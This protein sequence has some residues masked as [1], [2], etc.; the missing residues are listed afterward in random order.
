MASPINIGVD[1][2]STGLR[3]AYV[4]EGGQVVVLPDAV[5]EPWSWLLYE[6]HP[7][8]G[9]GMLFPSLKHKLGT[10][11]I[12]SV[13]GERK[14]PA[15]VVVEAFRALKQA[16]EGQI[17]KLVTQ[18][19]VSVPARYST[20]QR[21]AL[22]DAALQ[23]GFA[24]AHLVNDTVAAVIAYTAQGDDRATVLVYSMGYAGFE[25]GLVRAVRG[26]Y[27]ALG[28]EGGS[29]PSGGLIDLL[30]LQGW[31]N[32]LAEHKLALDTRRWDAAMGLQVRAA[33][34]MVKE[35]LSTDD[36]AIFPV[37]VQTP[38]GAEAPQVRFTRSEVEKVTTPSFRDTL[39]LAQRLLEQTN[40]T[41]ADVDTI[42]LVG[43]ST[44]IPVLSSLVEQTLGKKPVLAEAEILAQGAAL[45]A[46]RLEAM[47]L[48]TGLEAEKGEEVA[49]GLDIPV[50][51]AT[52]RAAIVASESTSVRPPASEHLVLVAAAPQQQVPV[53]DQT[54][55]LQYAH[56]LIEGGQ[57]EQARVF[58]QELIHEAQAILD[59]IPVRAPRPKSPVHPRSRR[60]L[61][62]AQKMI[63]EGQYEEAV[64]QSHLAWHES[65]D[66]PDI[67]EQMIDIHCQAAMANPTIESYSDAQRWLMCAYGHDESNVRAR[68]LLAER[69]YIQAKQLTDR[70]RRKD[71]LQAIEQCL[72]WEPEHAQGRE[73][74]Q[75]L[76]RR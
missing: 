74:Q 1:F 23:A 34:Q 49:E 28:Y 39:E 16:V 63:K 13:R 50:V 65:K 48:P 72:S 7:T 30:I 51:E 21:A 44:R 75:I 46:A 52:M 41:S 76:A 73:L 69:H 2:G 15:E 14:R 26:H 4:S 22:R 18:M 56:Q 42:L 6:S 17:S 11:E 24:D 8:R 59:R 5:V 35:K 53:P 55:F 43:G 67:F 20:S 57:E 54:A 62:M 68:Q 32:F 10:E 45:Y 47:P 3:V 38:D 12:L 71:A 37:S 40:M 33:A 36:Q 66:S 60:I 29:I 31:F 27:R 19:V 25:I 58:L 9:V 64:R 70:G 61:A